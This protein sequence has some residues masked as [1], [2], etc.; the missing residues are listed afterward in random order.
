MNY[1]EILRNLENASLFDLYRLKIALN[2]CL[3]QSDKVLAVK[4]QLRVG[5]EISYF[6]GRFNKIT[7]AVIEE[8]QRNCVYAKDKESG[9]RW[10]VPFYAI[11]LAHV[12]TDIHFSTNQ[13]ALDRNQ[14]HVGESI[15]FIGKNDKEMYGLI[16]Q[17]NPKTA[18]ITARDGS[19]W[20]V[21]Y[22]YLF[23]IV[24]AHAQES[25][26]QKIIDVTPK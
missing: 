24:D 7:D 13:A 12:N 9:K 2:V 20:R 22:R 5:M 17:L 25:S 8:I 15:G 19:R 1:S 3:E 26:S 14:L 10:G 6:S 21:D 4:R 18:S 11:N 16:T 23:Q